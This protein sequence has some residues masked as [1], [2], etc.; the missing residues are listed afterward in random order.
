M[1]GPKMKSLIYFL[2][3]LM[4]AANALDLI[5]TLIGLSLNLCE[6]NPLYYSL[7]ISGFLVLKIF[8]SFAI[9]LVC[10]LLAGRSKT[11]DLGISVLLSGIFI[12]FLVCFI[13]NMVMIGRV[14]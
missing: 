6:M 10:A 1:D 11:L 12:I 8:E 2:S 13:N 3:L 7:G 5:S 4:L 14:Y 9:V